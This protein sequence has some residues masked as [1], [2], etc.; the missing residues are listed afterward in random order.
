MTCDE[1]KERLIDFLYR[2]LPAQEHTAFEAHVA[3]CDACRREVESL[4]GTLTTARTAVRSTLDDP[5]PAGVRVAVLEAAR[6]A[7]GPAPMAARMPVK[8]AAVATKGSFWDFLRRPWVLPSFAAVSM[9]A[10][11]VFA[12]SVILHP[13]EAR[14]IAAPAAESEVATKD[15]EAVPEAKGE[16]DPEL[17]SRLEKERGGVKVASPRP[18]I[19]VSPRRPP[20]AFAPS[21]SYERLPPREMQ[22]GPAANAGRAS[23]PH[24]AAAKPAEEPPP[25][26]R[27]GEARRVAAEKPDKA[28]TRE[29]DQPLEK[30][31]PSRYATPP[32]PLAP[33]SPAA[34]PA[35][36]PPAPEPAMAKPAPAPQGAADE[37]A[38][39]QTTAKR[40]MR[41][42]SP[43]EELSQRAERAF[44]AQRWAEAAAAFREL[45]RLH[46]DN[47]LVAS[48]K[49]RQR[50]SET[51]LASSQKAKAGPPVRASDRAAP[52]EA[53]SK[54]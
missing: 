26:E 52:A 36:R 20:A 1:I 23:A 28:S 43:L 35:A 41:E 7:V 34:A 47:A 29:F 30:T 39:R 2:E 40:A 9:I 4:G 21:D 53:S 17:S 8:P 38:P 49:G 31:A 27:K 22:T 48:W 37:E 33:A 3:G 44:A 51:A 32:P 5:P 46:P 12:R 42:Q 15:N 18:A 50:A 45:I 11:F 19:V 25:P 24:K 13:E 10:V 54:K 6:A 16:R 14:Q